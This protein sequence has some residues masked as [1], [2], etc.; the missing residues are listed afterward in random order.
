MDP[1]A[2]IVQ[3]IRMKFLNVD[4]LK[5]AL[6]N[7]VK[8]KHSDF[9]VAVKTIKFRKTYDFISA[10]SLFIDLAIIFQLGSF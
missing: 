7:I 1:R 5:F 4:I 6:D 10:F 9:T 8:S 3:I 2:C